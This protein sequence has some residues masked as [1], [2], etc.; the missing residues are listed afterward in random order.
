MPVAGA[1]L[2]LREAGSISSTSTSVRRTLSRTVS[3][4][5]STRLP[6][7]T[8]PTSRAV[9]RTSASSAVSVIS[10]VR[11]SNAASASSGLSTRSARLRSASTCSSRR[12]TVRCTGRS[13]TRL[14]TRTPP[15]ATRRLPT[16]SSSSTTGTVSS[17]PAPR[18]LSLPPLSHRRPPPPPRPRPPPPGPALFVAPAALVAVHDRDRLVDLRLRHLGGDQGLAAAG[19]LGEPARVVPAEAAGD[20][21]ALD[22]VLA[23][24]QD[25]D[26]AVREAGPDQLLDH[27][28]GGLAVE[29]A[30]D[31]RRHLSVSL[32][33]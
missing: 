4:R 28:A 14:V 3:V 26:V 18:S 15:V 23:A 21:L 22:L 11:S 12:C 6:S 1:Y 25:R 13:T 17:R 29:R 5:S 9:L 31:G 10:T 2:R 32:C 27:L 8:S 19:G 30:D 33:R 20:D 7:E 16:D 24:L